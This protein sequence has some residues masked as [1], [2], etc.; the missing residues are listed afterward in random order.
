[1]G[2][3]GISIPFDERKNKLFKNWDDF[4]NEI[5]RINRTSPLV[6]KFRRISAGNL[7]ALKFFSEVW[8]H[9][10]ILRQGVHRSEQLNAAFCLLAT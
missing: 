8:I 10:V 9:F 7:V 5:R 3:L 6:A 1:M 2:K 4:M